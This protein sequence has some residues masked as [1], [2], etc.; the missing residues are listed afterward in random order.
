MTYRCYENLSLGN[1]IMNKI[2]SIFFVRKVILSR[3]FIAARVYSRWVDGSS[4]HHLP[5]PTWSASRVVAPHGEGS[6]SD[7]GDLSTFDA[8]SSSG[9]SQLRGRGG[10]GLFNETS[11]SGNSGSAMSSQSGAGSSGS[12]SSSSVV[13][14]AVDEGATNDEIDDDD[15]EEDEE[16]EVAPEVG[17]RARLLNELF[18]LARSGNEQASPSSSPV[19]SRSEF[20]HLGRVLAAAGV[21][22]GALDYENR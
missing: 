3:L 5:L 14:N 12:S 10:G 4:S 11:H 15:E 18:E 6:G 17:G 16:E 19:L 1:K 2:E 13:R 8:S 22:G 20:N 9:G 7:S 21:R